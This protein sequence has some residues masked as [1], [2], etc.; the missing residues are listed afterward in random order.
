MRQIKFTQDFDWNI[1]GSAQGKRSNSEG[2]VLRLGDS[3]ADKLVHHWNVAKY[4]ETGPT[5]TKEQPKKEATYSI[6]EEGAGWYS[7]ID[8]DG[9]AVDK[10]RGKEKAYNKLEELNN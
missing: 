5:E 2:D 4:H 8:E 1:D 9:E 7:L 6:R 3:M 10:V